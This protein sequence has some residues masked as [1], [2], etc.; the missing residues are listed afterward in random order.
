[1]IIAKTQLRPFLINV[2]FFPK[3]L[4]SSGI[5]TIPTIVSV[6][7]NETDGTIPTPPSISV[8]T[9][10]NAI[11]A[12]TRVIVPKIAAEIV[13]TSIFCFSTNA[14]MASGVNIVNS[15]PMAK[16]IDKIETIIPLPIPNA[17][18]TASFVLSLSLANENTRL[19]LV[20]YNKI[21]N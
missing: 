1:M 18:L 20:A 14:A 2:N 19:L 3:D 11:K 12:G 5:V 7:K 17:F 6:V 9:R 21:S 16:I 8:P 4:I 10:G 15:S 13:A